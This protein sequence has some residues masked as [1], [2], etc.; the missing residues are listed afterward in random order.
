MNNQILSILPLIFS[1]LAIIISVFIW[2]SNKSSSRYAQHYNLVSQAD[3]MFA[4]N[5]DFLRF[6][7]INPDE[8]EEEFGVTPD[9]LSYL[10][11]SFNAGS[12][13]NLLSTGSILNLFSNKRRR[14]P[15][16]KDSYWYNIL[17]NEPTQKAFPLI[18]KFFDSK[19][20]YIAKCKNTISLIKETH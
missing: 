3:K 4:E 14:K 8:I 15:F 5:K 13:S 1:V 20:I 7:G 10:L 16:K 18:Q 12:I 11:Q 19:N 6:H 2:I 17:K 9:E